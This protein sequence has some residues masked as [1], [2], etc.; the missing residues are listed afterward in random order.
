MSSSRF[1]RNALRSGDCGQLVEFIELERAE[2][3]DPYEGEPLPPDWEQLLEQKDTHQY[4]DFA[5]TK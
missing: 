2:L 5:L 3:T 4:G 1:S